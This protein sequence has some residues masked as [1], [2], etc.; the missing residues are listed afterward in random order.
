MQQ[1]NKRYMLHPFDLIIHLYIASDML[2]V[3]LLVACILL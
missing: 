3:F 2:A 1:R